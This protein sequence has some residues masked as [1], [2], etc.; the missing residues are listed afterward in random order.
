[1]K[2]SRDTNMDIPEALPSKH[3]VVGL[4]C[5]LII[6]IVIG[7]W[8]GEWISVL[9]KYHQLIVLGMFGTVLLWLILLEKSM[10]RKSK[11]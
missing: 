6:L 9:Q 8:L 5:V 1:M 11:V 3:L 4:L 2:E 10:A 7:L